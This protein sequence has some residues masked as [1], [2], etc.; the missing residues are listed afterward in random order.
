MQALASQTLGIGFSARPM[1]RRLNS[2]YAQR[3]IYALEYAFVFPLVFVVLYAILSYGILFAVR[4]GMQN[5]AEEGARAALRYQTVNAA[6]CAD[7]LACRKLA[8]ANAAKSGINWLSAATVDAKVCLVDTDDSCTSGAIP[9]CGSSLATRCQMIVT[10]NY[11]HEAH[12]LAPSLPGF[13]FLMP[14]KLQ[15]RASMLMS[16]PIAGSGI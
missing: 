14:S 5:A 8:A 13:G 3:G 10:V 15:G 2:L 1:R 6:I 16:D 4:L 7:Q 12:P 11:D 9:S